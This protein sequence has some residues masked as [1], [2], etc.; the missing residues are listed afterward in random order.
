MTTSRTPKSGLTALRHTY[1]PTDPLLSAREAAIER[2][3][4]LSTFW[5]DL[6]LGRVPQPYY[7][8]PRCPRWRLSEIRASVEAT[9]RTAGRACV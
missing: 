5:R 8:S 2:G 3:Q 4:A 7:V 1:R 6:K 9:R